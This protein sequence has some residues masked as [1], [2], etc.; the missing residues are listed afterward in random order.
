MYRADP[1]EPFPQNLTIYSG[2]VES[3]HK[4]RTI[5][6]MQ[7]LALLRW[8]DCELASYRDGNGRFQNVYVWLHHPT[9]RF[10]HCNAARSSARVSAR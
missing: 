3:R 1:H 9:L 6:K 5:T 7:A 10:V 8:H 4:V 2:P